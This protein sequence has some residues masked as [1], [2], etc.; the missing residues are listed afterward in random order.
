VGF[1]TPFTTHAEH[2][3]EIPER[4]SSDVVLRL[5]VHPLMLRIA[6]ETELGR[7][8]ASRAGSIAATPMDS[9]IALVS[10]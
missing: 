4:A 7:H 1:T 8:L 3:T 10:R 5:R 6:Y 2:R 9:T